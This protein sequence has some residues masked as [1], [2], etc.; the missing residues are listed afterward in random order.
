MIFNPTWRRPPNPRLKVRQKKYRKIISKNSKLMGR[1]L[2]DIKMKL[3]NA[4]KEEGR[5]TKGMEFRIEIAAGAAL[6]YRRLVSDIENLPSPVVRDAEDLDFSPQ[7]D[8]AVK[9]LA[10][11]AK[12]YHNRLVALGLAEDFADDPKPGRPAKQMPL[13]DNDELAAL[14]ERTVNPNIE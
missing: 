9:L 13:S 7:P 12:E 4:L 11:A 10:G 5:Y 8:E 6:L 2:N 14:I 3:R 1:E